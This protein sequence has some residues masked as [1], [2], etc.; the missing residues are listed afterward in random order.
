MQPWS[1]FR[2]AESSLLA[3]RRAQRGS[4]T[5]GDDA[6]RALVLALAALPP[7]AGAV[8]RESGARLGADV[9]SRRYHEDTLTHGLA[10]LSQAL[11]T[12][13]LGA[14]AV[15]GAFH[16]SA[17]VRYD[18]APALDAAAPG[19][20]VAFLEGVLEGY[21]SHAFNCR[22]HVQAQE[23]TL[24]HLELGEGRDVN[25]RRREAA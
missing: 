17:R 10:V 18:P 4:Q 2:E 14:L 6:D 21:L 8:A 22:A 11:Q 12:S 3:K 7:D 25:R 24:L 9:Y 23:P 5:L 16:R 19:V 20:R 15:E 1:S 13:G